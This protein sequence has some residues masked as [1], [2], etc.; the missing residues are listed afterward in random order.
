MAKKNIT[1]Q[2]LETAE[3]ITDLEERVSI[4]MHATHSLPATAGKRILNV[5]EKIIDGFESPKAKIT[6]LARMNP[7]V[8][9]I[10]KQL[11]EVTNG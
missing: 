8:E 10:E 1:D 3:E 9:R 2:I 6:Y 5:C 4:L 11:N 7:H